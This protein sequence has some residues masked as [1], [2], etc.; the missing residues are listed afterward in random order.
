MTL[1]LLKDRTEMSD[2]QLGEDPFDFLP[3]FFRQPRPDSGA[4]V[5]A[6]KNAQLLFHIPSCGQYDTEK[7]SPGSQ[8]PEAL[9]LLRMKINCLTASRLKTGKPVGTSGS[10]VFPSSAQ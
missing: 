1:N 7:H 5:V 6:L 10:A 8:A 9:R 2:Q 4:V 3:V